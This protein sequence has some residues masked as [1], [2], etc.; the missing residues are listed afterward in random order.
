MF[1][2]A[3]CLLYVKGKGQDLIYLFYSDALM[4]SEK[5]I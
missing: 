3:F 1:E 2:S 5:N 4:K